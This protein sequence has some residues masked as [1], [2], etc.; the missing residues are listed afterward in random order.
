MPAVVG[1]QD[2]GWQIGPPRCSTT[3]S[4]LRC[5]QRCT[6][7]PAIGRARPT[8]T[9]SASAP[10]AFDAVLCVTALC[11]RMNPDPQ[12]IVNEFARVDK[13]RRAGLPD[14]AGRKRLWRGHDEVTHT[15][16]GSA[17][18][19]MRSMVRV[20]RPRPRAR[21]R[22]LL[23]SGS[24]GGGHGHRRARQ[25]QERRRPQREWPR[26]PARSGRARR[27]ALLRKV[28]LPFGLSVIA[29]GRKPSD[30]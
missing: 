22:R 16:A 7:T 11:H 14:G 19:E 29:I 30:S 23:V 13:A 1:A 21:D 27:A 18:A 2:R 6:I 17:C 24:A 5:R 26:W 10:T 15:R 20:A 25:E 28:G 12:A 3:T 4:R 8:S 9:R